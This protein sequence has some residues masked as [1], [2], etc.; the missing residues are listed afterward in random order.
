MNRIL[1]TD[2]RRLLESACLSLK[3]LSKVTTDEELQLRI[4]LAL[5]ALNLQNPIA[6]SLEYE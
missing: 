5:Q 1:T 6:D 3:A 2:E 4:A